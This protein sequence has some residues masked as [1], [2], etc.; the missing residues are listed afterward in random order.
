M[1]SEISLHILD[2]VQNSIKAGAD[3][4]QI[5]ITVHTD[6]KKI[7]VEIKD[8]GC[9]MNSEQLAA[10]ENPF[11]T[12]RS[13]RKV[14]LG[15]PFFKQSAECTGGAFSILS[16]EGQGT[17][18]M[19]EYHMDHMDCIPI[20]DISATIYSLVIMNKTLDFLFQYQVDARQFVLDTRQMR[21]MLGG[22]PFDSSE[23][24]SFLKEFLYENKKEVDN[25]NIF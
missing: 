12:L 5:K 21:E 8:N 2:I 3:F 19:A 1:F 15:I 18:I 23:I 10:C 25:G 14:G 6:T 11:F 4:I 16:K 20:G 22:I 17:G 13:A 7:R 9:G 24:S